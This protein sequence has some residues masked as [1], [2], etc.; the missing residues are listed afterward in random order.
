MPLT[1]S[2]IAAIRHKKHV[3]EVRRT[4]AHDAGSLSSSPEDLLVCCSDCYQT[5]S[6]RERVLL[7]GKAGDVCGLCGRAVI[8]R[9]PR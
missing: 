3:A 7:L 9:G 4:I 8:A 6:A 5:A 2:Q 1:S